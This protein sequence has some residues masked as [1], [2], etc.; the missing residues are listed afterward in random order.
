FD[1]ARTTAVWLRAVARD[2]RAEGE[3][4]AVPLLQVA[5]GDLGSASVLQAWLG[6]LPQPRDEAPHRLAVA[7]AVAR[8]PEVVIAERQ[9][10]LADGRIASHVAIA[11]AWALARAPVPAPVDVR[12]PELPEWD[13]VRTASGAAADGDGTCGDPRVQAM[14]ELCRQG[15]LSRP[16]LRIQLEE[17]LWR[18]GGHPRLAPFELERALLRDLLLAGSNPGVKYQAHLRQDLRYSPGGMDRNDGFFA[19]AVAAWDFLEKPRSPM[20]PEHRLPD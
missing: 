17:A 12:V 2:L 9:Q 5:T 19:I 18:G 14:V 3:R 7:W 16:A 1:A 8:R 13:L 6:P 20:P 11:L 10:W 15:R 4:L